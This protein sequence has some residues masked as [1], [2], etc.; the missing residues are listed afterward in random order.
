VFGS[1]A[2]VSEGLE[3]RRP[4]SREM[5]RHLLR[6][7]GVPAA[8]GIQPYDPRVRARRGHFCPRPGALAVRE[9][10]EPVV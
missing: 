6:G 3:Q 2:G 7:Y 10:I 1:R 4:L 5:I 8:A 9:N